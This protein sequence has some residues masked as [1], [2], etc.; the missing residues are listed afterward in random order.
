MDTHRIVLF[1]ILTL[2]FLYMS[3]WFL[4]A[5]RD[6]IT[7]W[8]YTNTGKGHYSVPLTMVAITVAVLHV[9][10]YPYIELFQEVFG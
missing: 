1:C 8:C 10:W 7:E 6:I 9:G 2:F 3:K 5:V 4:I